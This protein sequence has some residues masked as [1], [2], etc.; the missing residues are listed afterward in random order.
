M[1]LLVLGVKMRLHVPETP[2]SFMAKA[3][4]AFWQAGGQRHKRRRFQQERAPLWGVALLA[5]CPCGRKCSR[6]CRSSRRYGCR[7]VD[8]LSLCRLVKACKCAQ[9]QTVAGAWISAPT[10][11]RASFLAISQYFS[12]TFL[13]MLLGSWAQGLGV[14]RAI[15]GLL[16]TPSQAAICQG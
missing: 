9:A 4:T 16:A 12:P 11:P 3:M 15:A 1:T 14:I 5:D 8:D 2:V 13:S 10:S 6:Y 7:I